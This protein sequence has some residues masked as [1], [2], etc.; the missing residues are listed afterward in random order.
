MIIIGRRVY[1]AGVIGLGIVELIFAAFAEV[2]IPVSAHLPGYH[3]LVWAV[4]GALIAAG[5][6]INWPRTA[7]IAAVALA[8]VFA[9]GMLATELAPAVA[10][11]A[12]WG[13][14]QAVAESA[15]MALGAVLAYALS[16]GVSETR[17]ASLTR[18]A[19]WAFG[20]CLL[21]FGVS[22]FA[23]AKFTASLVPAWLPPS[24]LFWAY[25]TGLAQL[26]AGLA[27]LSGIQARL[28]AILLTAMYVIFGLLV[29][30]PS[31]I[32][33][34]ASHDNWAENAINLVLTGAAWVLAD[35]L[36]DKRLPWE[37]T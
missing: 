1:S 18:I 29:H 9:L 22:H 2:W 33:H 26:A 27:M 12:V 20:V 24:Q 31:V 11:P 3:I 6:A 34:P 15:A 10:R 32:A 30:I 21:V 7:R 37:K 28:A 17:S 4:A 16:P 8:A 19:R 23:Y 5:L 13:N 35:S 36:A 25:A 14:W